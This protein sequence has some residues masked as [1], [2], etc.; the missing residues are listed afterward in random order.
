LGRLQAEGLL[1]PVGSNCSGPDERRRAR[2]ARTLVPH[3]EL[4]Y[5]D[6]NPVFSRDGRVIYFTSDRWIYVPLGRA[7]GPGK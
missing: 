6:A 7:V 1:P 3:H 2:G 4:K 5:F